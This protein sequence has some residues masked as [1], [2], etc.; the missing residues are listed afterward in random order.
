[1]SSNVFF[2]GIPKRVKILKRQR[3]LLLLRLWL[4]HEKNIGKHALLLVVGDAGERFPM[5]QG[6][7]YIRRRRGGKNCVNITHDRTRVN[8]SSGTCRTSF[9]FLSIVAWGPHTYTS[10]MIPHFVFWSPLFPVW[11]G[12]LRQ[13]NI[14]T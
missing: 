5:Y 12:M 6:P 10:M 13:R 14:R 11:Q 3:F 7:S 1:M 4:S 2:I 9:R 8:P